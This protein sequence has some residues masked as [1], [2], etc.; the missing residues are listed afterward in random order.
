[1]SLPPL[2]QMRTPVES[3]IPILPHAARSPKGSGKAEVLC[4]DRTTLLADVMRTLSG[5]SVPNA[6]I[7]LSLFISAFTPTLTV[8]PSCV[9]DHVGAR[10]HR[11]PASILLGLCRHVGLGAVRGQHLL[12]R[13][14]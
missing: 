14:L 6:R 10:H 13:A 9:P 12:R 8:R 11:A 4:T 2:V 1:M 3:L 5:A 7:T